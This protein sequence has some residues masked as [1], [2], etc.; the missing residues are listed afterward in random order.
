MCCCSIVETED[1]D[2][3]EQEAHKTAT[4]E[5]KTDALSKPEASTAD[6]ASAGDGSAE[7]PPELRMDEYDDEPDA[8]GSEQDGSDA[9][10]M[11]D[12]DD[13]EEEDEE[14]GMSFVREPGTGQVSN[15]VGGVSGTRAM[16]CRRTLQ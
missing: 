9:D 3:D 1:A 13:K 11:M 10:D 2:D 8:P 5:S 4:A 6:T 7:L 12:D 16:A 15:D 14:M